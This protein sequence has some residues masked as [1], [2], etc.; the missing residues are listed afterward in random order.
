MLVVDLTTTFFSEILIFNFVKDLV[1]CDMFMKFDMYHFK[2][3]FFFHEKYL[4]K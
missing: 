3:Y 2:Q 4:N 1:T